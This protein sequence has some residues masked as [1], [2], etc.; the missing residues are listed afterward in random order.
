MVYE[1]FSTCFENLQLV[2]ERINLSKPNV[3]IFFALSVIPS[4]SKF[5]LFF[6]FDV[7]NLFCSLETLKIKCFSYELVILDP[8]YITNTEPM[9]TLN[10]PRY[11]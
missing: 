1:T 8:F 2:F 9:K 6:F 3:N 5:I 11:E 4:P 10:R 7:P